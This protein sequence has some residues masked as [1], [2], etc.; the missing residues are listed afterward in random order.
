MGFLLVALVY[1]ARSPIAYG[2]VFTTYS[3]FVLFATRLFNKELA[4]V[5]EKSRS[6]LEGAQKRTQSEKLRQVYSE[7]IRVL[8]AYF[9]KRP[10]TLRHAEAS[11]GSL[12]GLLLALWWEYTK[13]PAFKLA[14][15]ITY[16][17]TIAVSE[18]VIGRWRVHRDAEMR[19]LTED[20]IELETK[21][22]TPSP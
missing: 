21:Q 22:P 12:V 9:I 18:V 15:Y 8:E 17:A 5:I 10:Q 1:V 20:K 16:I 11:A 2:I 19:L 3:L 7:A 4:D 13:E 6:R 14:A